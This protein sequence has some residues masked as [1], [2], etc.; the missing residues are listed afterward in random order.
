MTRRSDKPDTS[1]P[2]EPRSMDEATDVALVGDVGPG[3]VPP[4]F[5]PY[6]PLLQLLAE[7]GGLG[8]AV[9][10]DPRFLKRE[11]VRVGPRDP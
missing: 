7:S 8:G 10:F 5:V 3:V 1:I 2:I 4:R 9:A 6:Q 11:H